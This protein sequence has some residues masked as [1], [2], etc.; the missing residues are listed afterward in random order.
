MASLDIS[1]SIME[2]DG[3]KLVDQLVDNIDMFCDK[4]R[5]AEGIKI[6]KQEDIKSSFDKTKINI[7]MTE[8]GLT[9]SDVEKIL[10][11]KY[12]IYMEM[13]SANLVMGLSGV[14]N[15]KEDFLRL[16]IA[17]RNKRNI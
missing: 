17:Y 9:G 7:D 13:V 10:R 6:M 16:A 3:K 12:N 14:G 5:S 11:E 2:K 4:V 15:S 8:L 1:A